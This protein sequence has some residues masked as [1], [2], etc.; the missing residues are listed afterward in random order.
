M[1][2]LKM[3]PFPRSVHYIDLDLYLEKQKSLWIE[4][5]VRAFAKA[6]S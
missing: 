1:V 5:F 2:T 4:E 6:E 3:A